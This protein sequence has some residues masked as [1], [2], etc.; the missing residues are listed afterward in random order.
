MI[1]VHITKHSR[2]LAKYVL[3]FK[4]CFFIVS[5]ELFQS[6]FEMISVQPIGNLELR[7]LVNCGILHL[8]T[9]WNLCVDQCMTEV[10]MESFGLFFQDSEVAFVCDCIILLYFSYIL[11]A[12]LLWGKTQY[13]G[14]LLGWEEIPIVYHHWVKDSSSLTVCMLICK[15]PQDW[16]S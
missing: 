10:N 4:L 15:N 11:Q 6:E 5:E 3:V 9:L 14:T 12:V 1:H 16:R 13:S 7:N 8:L 2:K